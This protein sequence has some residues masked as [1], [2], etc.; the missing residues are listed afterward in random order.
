MMKILVFVVSQ[1]ADK[2]HLDILRGF[3]QINTELVRISTS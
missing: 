1:K 3:F 2:N